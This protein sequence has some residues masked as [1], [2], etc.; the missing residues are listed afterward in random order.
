MQQRM[1]KDASKSSVASS[2]VPAMSGTSQQQLRLGAGLAMK[3]KNDP[4]FG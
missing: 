4:G 2:N 1:K 3:N